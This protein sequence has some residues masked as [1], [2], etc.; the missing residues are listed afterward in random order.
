VQAFREQ[1]Y[2][3]PAYEESIVDLAKLIGPDHVL[4]GSDWPHPEGLARPL[5]FFGDIKD[6]SL[7]DQRQIMSTNL[8]DL[9]G[10]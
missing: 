3:M 2:V 7:A 6:L 5:D 4:F 8:K 1:V 9:L 10:V